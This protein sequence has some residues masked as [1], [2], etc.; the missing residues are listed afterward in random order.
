MADQFM[1]IELNY[2]CACA[3]ENI[4]KIQ[5]LKKH[6]EAYIYLN[7]RLVQK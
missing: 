5:G 6:I 4:V 7:S 2:K 1:L 3:H